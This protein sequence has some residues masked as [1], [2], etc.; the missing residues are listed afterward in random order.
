METGWQDGDKREWR[1]RGDERERRREERRGDRMV[2]RGRGECY[3]IRQ[4]PFNPQSLC[5]IAGHMHGSDE[6]EERRGDGLDD[7]NGG[8]TLMHCV[9][10]CLCVDHLD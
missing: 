1:K 2:T 5:S 9:I 4:E 10:Q 6:R 7:E 8:S 3:T